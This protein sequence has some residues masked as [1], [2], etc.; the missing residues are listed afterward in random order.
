MK[1]YKIEELPNLIIFGSLG[2]AIICFALYIFN[3]NYGFLSKVV[4][5]NEYLTSDSTFKT[6]LPNGFVKLKVNKCY[7]RFYRSSGGRRTPKT[8][9]DSSIFLV[10][11]Q[12]PV[13]GSNLY[14]HN[15]G[16]YSFYG[17]NQVSN[18]IS[19]IFWFQ[20]NSNY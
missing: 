2:I 7:G 16:H 5:L 20:T 12:K 1:K 3:I 14:V 9:Y 18:G 13:I 15:F 10:E 4:D 6:V 8:D 11:T 17:N 19:H